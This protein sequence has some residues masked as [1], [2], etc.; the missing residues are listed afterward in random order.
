M[1]PEDL[2]AVEHRSLRFLARL[3]G[4]QEGSVSL[5]AQLSAAD[6][7]DLLTV[8]KEL[9]EHLRDIDRMIG[10]T[11]CNSAQEH[12]EREILGDAWMPPPQSRLTQA[13]YLRDQA[14]KGE[15]WRRLVS[16][17]DRCPHGRH[18]GDSCAGWRGPGL[19]DGGCRGGLSL[20]NPLHRPGATIGVDYSGNMIEM[21]EDRTDRVDPAKWIRP[22]RPGE[23]LHH[24]TSEGE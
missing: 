3:A 18:V 21:P 17:L 19:Y 13:Q 15:R 12:R 23:M 8:I 5:A 20:G 9:T 14:V 16:D 1:K 4:E 7:P 6:V 11:Y 24:H 10:V 2:E 22:P